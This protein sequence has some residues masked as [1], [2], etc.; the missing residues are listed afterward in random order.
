MKDTPIFGCKEAK[1]A[2]LHV[3][4]TNQK[5]FTTIPMNRSLTFWR[6][7]MCLIVVLFSLQTT[8]IRAKNAAFPRIS[9]PKLVDSVYLFASKVT[10]NAGEIV[11]IEVTT[12]SFLDI[13]QFTLPVSWNP[14]LLQFINFSNLTADLANFNLSNFNATNV[15]SGKLV[16]TWSDVPTTITSGT[17]FKMMFRVIG[18]N[19]TPTPISFA[20]ILP[21][22]QL[23]F[24]KTGAISAAVARYNGHVRINGTYCASRPAGLSCQTAPLLSSAEFPFYGKLPNANTT[25]IPRGTTLCPGTIENNHWLSF[26]ASSTSLTFKARALSC[27]TGQG[28]QFAVYQTTDCDMFQKVECINTVGSGLEDSITV[29]NLV[30][31]RTYYVMIDGYRGDICDYFISITSGQIQN[32]SQTLTTPTISGPTTICANRTNQT[33][34]IPA[35]AN[36]DGYFW[37]TTANAATITTPTSGATQTSATINWG[38][39]SDS[40]CVRMLARC[41]TTKWVC[42]AVKVGTPNAKSLAVTICNGSSFLFKG[43]NLTMAGVYKDTLKNLSGCDSVVTL[44]LTT[45]AAATGDVTAIKCSTDPYRWG[46]VDRRTEGDYPITLQTAAGCDSIVTLHLFNYPVATKSVDSTICAGSSVLIGGRTFSL[47]VNTNVTVARGSWR[48]CDSTI[49]LK[50]TVIDFLMQT[51]TK[52]NDI[53]CVAP[54]ATLTAVF[55]NQP[56]TA[57]MGYEWKNPS[58]TIVGTTQSV[59]V[60]QGGTY[61]LTVTARLNGIVCGKSTT[62]NVTKTGTQPS[63]PAITG[64]TLA[65]ETGNEIYSLTAPVTGFTYNWTVSNGTFTTQTNQ[66]TATWTA[67]ATNSKVCVSAQNGCGFSDTSCVT[68]DIGRVPGPLS[69]MGNSTVCPNEKTIFRVTPTANTTYLW[70]ATGGTA[71]TPLNLDSVSVQWAAIN[72]RVTLTPSSRCGT[73]IPTNFDIQ[74]NNIL[75]D[76]VPIQGIATPCSNDT[77]TYTVALS[78]TTTEY[79]WQVPTGA[80]VISGQ[81]TRTVKVVWGSFSGNG[82]VF[83]TT[84][85]ACKLARGVAF[86]VNVK[87][88]AFTAPTINGNRTVCPNTQ[89]SFWTPRDSSI[90]SYAWTVP[91]EAIILRGPTTDSIRVNWDVSPSGQVCLDIETTCGVKRRTCVNIE[92]RADLDSLVIA[93]GRTICKDSTMKFCVPDDGSALRFLWQIPS[94]TGGT[95]VSGQGTSCLTVKFASTGG[96]VRVIPVGGCSDSKLSRHDVAVKL[97]PT[98]VGTISGKNTVCVNSTETYTIPQQNDVVRYHWTIPTGVFFVGDSTSNSVSLSINNGATSGFITVRAENSCGIGGGTTLR[99]TIV[100]RPSVFA[101][102][103]T[104]VCGRTYLLNGSSNG[105]TKTWSVVTKP[106]SSSPSFAFFDR[107]QTLVT[108]TKSGTYT[109]KFEETNG[110]ECSAVDSVSITFRDAPIATVV[111]QTCNQ[112][113][114]EYRVELAVL[115][116]GAPFSIGGSVIGAFQGSTFISNTI[117]S[118]TPYFFIV[119][120]AFGCKSDTISGT[121]QCPCYTSAGTLRADSLVVCF[122]TTGKAMPQGDA[123]L[124]LNDVS[125]YLLHTGTATQIGSI[126]DRNKTGIFSFNPLTMTYNRVYY[127]TFVVGDQAVNGNVD[128]TKRCVSKTRGIPIVFKDKIT[129]GLVGDTT[130]CRFSP[131]S[132]QFK[133]NQLGFFDITYQPDSGTISTAVNLQ[134]NTIVNVNSGFSATYKLLTVKDK[135]GCK[136]QIT[137][138]ARVNLRPFPISQAGA[139]RS[140]C[141]TSVQLDAAENFSYIG[142]WSSLTSGVLIAD[143][144]D[145]RTVVSRLQNGN[146]YFIWTVRDSACSGYLIRDTVQITVPLVPKAINLSLITQVGVSVSGNVT[147]SAPL[148][149]YSVTRLTN[150][151][152]GRFDLFSNGSFNYIPDP[153]FQGIVTFKYLICSSL[154]NQLCDTGS[155]RILIQPKKDTVRNTTIDIPNCITPNGDGKNE[156]LVIDNLDQFTENELVIFNRWGDILYK[157]KPYKNEWGGTNQ[158]GNPLPE[159]TYYYVLRLNTTDGKILRG[160]LTILR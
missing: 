108:V 92:V 66:I 71:Q 18:S 8:D 72:G 10:A 16:V 147:E 86:P 60:N 67:N 155:V 140:I 81:G 12:G 109:F 6:L 73:G 9:T 132:L 159:G 90:R 101:G 126:V 127:V 151:T 39:V 23:R 124:D 62:I 104:T 27:P 121:K 115:G 116:S 128:T 70:S 143:S 80:T 59:M 38:S 103:D 19:A 17:L 157:S 28:I 138:S 110:G 4:I 26:I 129:A 84:K 56:P 5:F 100:P 58:G 51:P 15:A 117:A 57:I 11:T 150:P 114:T 65:C 49:N 43:Q 82:D 63:K 53:T 112:E 146:N 25:T 154:C 122:G 85:N 42:Q 87:N 79:A 93:G 13:E 111:D 106:V 133:C 78:A 2:P 107:S 88:A 69:I 96:T 158:S 22:D 61:T 120:D 55:Q 31:G 32:I 134:N 94:I 30:A 123:K 119:T 152:S 24:T 68:V 46:G 74:I 156:T 52:S 91:P 148:G 137:D 113:A 98:I 160:D 45:G 37:K 144:S 149:T 54:Q 76:S 44:T 77:T 89:I 1:F 145:A 14:S 41:D 102:R 141:N 125:D 48:G 97:P 75:P 7:A 20:D 64:Q 83:L 135:N 47:P 105:T 99:I 130:V 118:G 139:D 34:S 29:A 131:V 142:R 21:T 153:T 40:V 36:A 136:A 95:I 35:V 3:S 50:L 33:Y